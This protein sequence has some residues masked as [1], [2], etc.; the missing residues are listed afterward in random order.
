[1]ILLLN[2][3]LMASLLGL[4]LTS[5]QTS[6]TPGPSSANLQSWVQMEGGDWRVEPDGV[7]VGTN[8]KGW[9]TDPEKSGSW[10]RSKRSYNDFIL[11]M[12][13]S[14]VGNSGLFFRSALEK[15][16][17]FTG[18]EFQILD[19]HGRPPSKHT[20][21]SLYDV[22]APVKN[23]SLPGG[24]WNRLRIEVRGQN[25]QASLNGERILNTTLSRKMEGYV[26][27]QNHDEKTE[28]RVRNFRIQDL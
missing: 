21:G 8:G 7:L 11:E 26:G 25:L 18:Y 17:A 13:Y 4:L 22:L 12:E 3:C 1:M 24:Q 20:T 16:P 10:I 14:I 5:C 6:Q 23:M 19:D 28:I 9:S 2:R 27:I 15:N